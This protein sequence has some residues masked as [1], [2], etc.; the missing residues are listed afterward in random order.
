MT[1]FVYDGQYLSDYGFVVCAFDAGDSIDI[2][3]IGADIKFEKVS[4]N[5]GKRFGLASTGYDECIVAEFDICKNPDVYDGLDMRITDEERRELVRWLNRREFL[6]FQPIDD[7]DGESEQRFYNASF[8]ISLI[9]SGGALYGLRLN[10]ETDSPFGYGRERCVALDFSDSNI[11]KTVRDTSDDVGFIYP[12]LTITCKEDGDISLYNEMENCRTVIKNCVAG[13]VISMDCENQIV[14]TSVESHNVMD[15][16][17]YE[18]FRIGNVIGD[19]INR[20][21][22]SAPCIAEIRYRPVIKD[23]P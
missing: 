18:F 12:Y 23:I 8:N 2:A 7:Y 10:M 5:G 21:S 3:S 22:A 11:V 16:F 19:R 14:Q 6:V 1:N 13:E 9:E 15:D 17:N 4:R 20:I